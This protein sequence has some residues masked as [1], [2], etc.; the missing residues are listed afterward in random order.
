M[1]ITHKFKMALDRR[2]VPATVD[3]VQGNKNTRAVEITLFC[4]NQPWEVP[5]GVSVMV[6]FGKPDGTGGTYDT[7]EDGSSAVTVAGNVITAIL[8]K[9]V[10]TVP[11]C[12][13]AQVELVKDDQEMATFA[14]V[15]LVEPDPS[16]GAMDSEDYV[17]LSGYV[18]DEVHR[19]MNDEGVRGAG[20]FWVHA[21]LDYEAGTAEVV[22]SVEE[23]YAAHEANMD[24]CM[25][26]TVTNPVMNGKQNLVLQTVQKSPTPSGSYYRM[27]FQTL[28]SFK[29]MASE[30][31]GDWDTRAVLYE[32]VVSKFEDEI[33]NVCFRTRILTEDD[34]TGSA[35][36]CVSFSVGY[37]EN[38]ADKTYA[39]IEAAFAEGKRICGV[40]PGEFG[41]VMLPDFYANV[42]EGTFTFRGTI[43]MENNYGGVDTEEITVLMRSDGTIE[44][45][46]NKLVTTELLGEYLPD[47]ARRKS[48]KFFGAV[49]DGAT[50]DTE[51]FSR[52]LSYER[53]VFVPGGT[54]LLTAGLVIGDNCELELAQ[55]TVLNFTQT[56]GNC[57]TLGMSSSLKGNHAT[58]N[59]PYAFS[60]KVVYASSA[61]TEDTSAP[62]PFTRWDPQWKSG[63]Y[64]S[65]LN[66]CKADNRGFHYSVDGKCN[67]TAVYLSADGDANL[68][69]MWGVHFSGLR[70]AG[71]FAYGI[72]A[73]NFSEGWLHEMRIDAF[74]D[75]CETAVCL[76]DC[77]NAYVSAI[78][79]PRRALLSDNVTY[80]PYAKH[81]IKLIRSKN[82]DLSGS[83]VWDWDATNTLWTAG[84][85]Y[86][87]L[88]MYGECR[89]AIINAFQYYET[90][91]DIRDLIY[92]DTASNLKQ[93]TILQEPFD[94]WFKNRGNE[95]YFFDGYTEKKLATQ[96]ELDQHFTT[97][98]VKGFTDVLTTA[99]DTDGTIYN[100]IGYR[101]G[102]RLDGYD[103]ITESPYYGVTGFIPCKV[104]SKIYAAD[105]S[106]AT[107]D[108]Y[109]RANFYGKDL[110]MLM[111][112]EYGVSENAEK[113]VTG[114]SSLMSYEETSN[115]FVCT[116]LS[117]ALTAD[118]A[119]VRFTFRDVGF[120]AKPTMAVDE[121]IRYTVEGFLADGIRVKAE[122]VVGGT[123]HD[124]N[125]DEGE[126]GHIKGRTHYK[127]LV[128]CVSETPTYNEDE[129]FFE[130]ETDW[131][132][133]VGETYLV[134]YNGTEY[135][136]V[137]GSLD[138][139]LYIG[140]LAIIE[141]GYDTGE[142]FIIA[143]Q[144]GFGLQCIDLNGAT[145]I[146]VKITKIVY[147]TIPQEYIPHQVH[148][149]DAV[150]VDGAYEQITVTPAQTKAAI[151]AGMTIML[152]ILKVDSSSSNNFVYYIPC[153]THYT[154]PVTGLYPYQ[155]V[156]CGK[157]GLLPQERIIRLSIDTTSG[158]ENID[159]IANLPWVVASGD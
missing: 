139:I 59:V 126:A 99:I 124:W 14:F 103:V 152:R 100:G 125:A 35:D 75:A 90:S 136:C 155:L 122:N 58:V 101:I 46:S 118:V 38:T 2:G 4:G 119:Y 96:E 113:I 74:I 9:Q 87:H 117:V 67:G 110:N 78:I 86:Q 17:N 142:P 71:A 94:R 62:P 64:V 121:E 159:E 84:G 80:V 92:T 20:T 10:L 3:V 77:N 25:L 133:T 140:N 153:V 24:C 44:N 56:S 109:C 23:I 54:Y 129:N 154:I 11:G 111:N 36:F 91:Y 144:S 114:S 123:T 127:E 52:A 41:D 116:V 39:E 30:E 69:F 158:T 112:G 81:G 150:E 1:L 15:I 137:A 37:P 18:S 83:R 156:F 28:E 27:S 147:V 151:D 88:C 32:V 42:N 72:H 120:G 89:G 157:V 79:E 143:C 73:Q 7:L 26:A 6:R 102:C 65:D 132:P 107:R 53:V 13:R 40:I 61:T 141:A 105:L 21:T 134:N 82:A 16:V 128:E 57:I 104:G 146:T 68:T 43:S 149:I 31:T 29:E 115:G 138:D 60:G 106:W 5:E 19:I 130:F 34:Q 49:G 145:E 55:D 76:E 131:S 93:I 48:I 63:R 98:R 50:D 12:V 51:A 22:E 66:I 8:A 95:P 47:G 70:I 45:F 33:Q 97:D 85:E 135:T 108:G 148:W